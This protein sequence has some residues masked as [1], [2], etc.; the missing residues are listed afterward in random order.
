MK[1][2]WLLVALMLGAF[3]SACG[4]DNKST[5]AQYD[6]PSLFPQGAAQ[7]IVVRKRG[8]QIQY[9]SATFYSGDQWVRQLP[10]LNYSNVYS[11]TLIRDRYPQYPNSG[12]YFVVD[13]S[14]YRRVNSPWNN[15]AGYEQSSAAYNYSSWTYTRYAC[16]YQIG[17]WHYLYYCGY[18]SASVYHYYPN[19][20]NY[21]GW[22]YQPVYYASYSYYYYAP[23]ATYV[24]DGWT[25]YV[26][27]LRSV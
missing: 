14:Q 27:V 11:H 19:Y 4:S 25:Y 6:D 21:T 23:Y 13:P 12:L 9:A 17:Y 15:S 24:I 2:R 5:P 18:Q 26:Y 20:Y 8:H 1:G 22:I 10:Y 3:L 7:V 16:N